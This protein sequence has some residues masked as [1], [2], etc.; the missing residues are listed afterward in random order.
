[1]KTSK[2]PFEEYLRAFQPAEPSAAL[3]GRAVARARGHRRA[4]LCIA[5]AA[6]L[7]MGIFG[8]VILGRARQSV[9]YVPHAPASVHAGALYVTLSRGGVDALCEQLDLAGSQLAKGPNTL[10]R[11]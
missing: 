11:N 5:A 8:I 3:L 4:K 10:A 2:D 9:P 7:L 1:M 6:V